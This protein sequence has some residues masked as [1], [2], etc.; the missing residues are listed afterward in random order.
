M[1]KPLDAPVSNSK[2]TK[3]ASSVQGRLSSIV[4][5]YHYTRIKIEKMNAR[6]NNKDSAN[7]VTK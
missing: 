4:A 1:V 6:T 2:A 5:L 3:R 7:N